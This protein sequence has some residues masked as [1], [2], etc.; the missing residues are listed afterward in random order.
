MAV[1]NHIHKKH[2][3]ALLKAFKRTLGS[4]AFIKA[5]L[6]TSCIHLF[7]QSLCH[8]HIC[9]H[10]LCHCHQ[11]RHQI[12]VKP[13]LHLELS[14]ITSIKLLPQICQQHCRTIFKLNLVKVIRQLNL[15]MIPPI[16]PFILCSFRRTN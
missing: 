8:H 12:L 2:C 5:S 14:W 9:H 16:Y 10:H 13:V 3:T 11:H 15:S 7:H 4:G 1:H 6:L